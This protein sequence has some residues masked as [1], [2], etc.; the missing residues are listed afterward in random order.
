MNQGKEYLN[1]DDIEQS[2]SIEK[3]HKKVSLNDV[4]KYED[5][6]EHNDLDAE[7]MIKKILKHLTPRQIEI[8]ELLGKG[9]ETSY[10]ALDLGISQRKVRHHRQK[11]K[12]VFD[13]FYPNKRSHPRS[14]KVTLSPISEGTTGT[15]TKPTNSDSIVQD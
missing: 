2:S 15:R 12:E 3:H 11:I 13:K 1:E 6:I 8:F 10:I 7:K 4:H 5:I 9:L 14:K